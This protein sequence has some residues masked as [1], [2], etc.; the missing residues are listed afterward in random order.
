[1]P[2]LKEA[3]P[4]RVT[5]AAPTGP[6]ACQPAGPQARRPGSL[7]HVL[8]PREALQDGWPCT[9]SNHFVRKTEFVP[10]G[11]VSKGFALCIRWPGNSLTMPNLSFSMGARG[12]TMS[13]QRSC[14][15]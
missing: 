11:S 1:M 8:P 10:G 7:H 13:F 3:S 4:K 15:H 14:F 12:A 5:P 2:S 6:P 9:A